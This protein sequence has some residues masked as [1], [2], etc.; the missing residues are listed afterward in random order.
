VSTL[1]ILV[2]VAGCGVTALVVVAMILITPRGA[3]DLRA[4]ATDAQSSDV[5]RAGAPERTARVPTRP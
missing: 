4:Q 2:A 3:V 5:R 1:E